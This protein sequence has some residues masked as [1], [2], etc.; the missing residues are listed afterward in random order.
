MRRMALW[1]VAVAAVLAVFTASTFSAARQTETVTFHDLA[2]RPGHPYGRLTE[3][4]P[5]VTESN[6]VILAV[7][8][9]AYRQAP[10]HHRQEQFLVGLEGALEYDI[11][12]VV[13]RLGSTRLALVPSNV[14]HGMVNEGP[15]PALVIEF[16]PV[17]RSEWL[18]PH[19]KV[20]P[21]PQ[22]P[23]PGAL[24]KDQ[25]VTLDFDLA[26]EGWQRQSNG[27]RFKDLAG[28]TIRATFWDL[29]APNA[30]AELNQSQHER[31]VYVLGGRASVLNETNKR[32]VRAKM[33]MVVAPAAPRVLLSSV[34]QPGTELVVFER[35]A[36]ER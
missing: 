26:S 8:P 32:E 35:I 6:S 9:P 16:Q 13:H 1:R 31:F 33:L 29:S 2:S 7:V 23:I 3:A 5:V 34:A 22:S 15:Q 19:P 20:P 28:E 24:R 10:H 18:P 11:G 4:R 21:Q 14:P 36:P 27:A 17:R 12:G 25:Q 30:S